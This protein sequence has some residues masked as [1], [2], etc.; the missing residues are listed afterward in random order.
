LIGTQSKLL[1]QGLIHQT[2]DGC[3]TGYRSFDVL[4]CIIAAISKRLEQFFYLEN[5]LRRGLKLTN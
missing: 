4:I 2:L 3:L 5:L 1:W